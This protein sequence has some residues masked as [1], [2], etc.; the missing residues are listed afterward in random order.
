LDTG[1]LK[2]CGYQN[3][4]KRQGEISKTNKREKRGG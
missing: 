2:A 1:K 3:F 4:E